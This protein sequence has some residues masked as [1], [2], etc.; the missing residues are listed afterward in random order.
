MNRRGVEI[1]YGDFAVGAKEDFIA[2]A[3]EQEPYVDMS[4]L[5]VYDLNVPDFI[6][7][8]ERF[9]AIL[10]GKGVPFPE[11]PENENMGY[12][13]SQISGTTG[14]IV[15]TTI[16]LESDE[17]YT[18]Q[19]LTFTFDKAANI[20]PTNMNIKWYRDTSETLELL[21]DM[22]FTPDSTFY[23]CRNYVE[24]YNRIVITIS[25]LNTSFCRL[26]IRAIDYGY[27]TMFKGD[28]LRNVKVTHQFSPLATELG[29]G[30]VDFTLDSKHDINYVFQPHQ[31][32]STFF[33]GELV[34]TTFVKSSKRKAKKLWDVK[35]EDYISVLDSAQFVGGMYTNKNAVELLTEIFAVAKVPFQVSDEL[36]AATVTGYLPWDSCRNS[37]MQ[38]CFAIGAVITTPYS[39]VVQIGVAQKEI[40]QTIPLNRILQGQNFSTSDEIT[41][42][43]IFSHSYTAK[44]TRETLYDA[45]ESGEGENIFLK[46]SEP[47]Y[48]VDVAQGTLIEAGTNYAIFNAETKYSV[49]RGYRYTHTTKSHILKDSLLSPKDVENIK[50][51]E[52]ATLVSDDKIEMLLPK[53]YDWF[54]SATQTNLK[55]VEGKHNIEIDGESKIEYD[56]PVKLGERISAQTEYLG[57]VTGM[58]VKESFNLNGGIVIKEAVIK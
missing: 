41:G 23:F 9:I 57:D 43:E 50:R 8:C 58:I 51:I 36:S 54:K 46:F 26:K 45:S 47:M 13:S 42:V 49:L 4:E 27:G 7:P 18:S 22:D 16:T 39:D 55:I 24:K 2:Q 53:C 25:S 1:A 37:I 19:G 28:E 29:I 6:N 44:G 38:V 11:N 40:V 56:K 3:S 30:T 20:F 35:S 31:P 5:Q 12:V 33:N 15:P 52:S 21:S 32:L 48:N 34:A 14:D 10:N 17:L